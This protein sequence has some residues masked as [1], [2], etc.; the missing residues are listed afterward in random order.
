VLFGFF[1]ISWRGHASLNLTSEKL[2]QHL[3]QFLSSKT[4]LAILQ[5][6]PKMAAGLTTV[7][8]LYFA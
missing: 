8:P 2:I 3:E 6:L 1:P 5:F 7:H 4:G